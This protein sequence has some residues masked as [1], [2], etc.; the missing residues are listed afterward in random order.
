MK[1]PLTLVLPWLLLLVIAAAPLALRYLLVESPEIARVCDTGHSLAC[2]VRHAT[3]LGFIT[4]NLGGLRIGVFGWV[5]LAAMVLALWRPGVAT[6]WL[7]AATALFAV[8]LYCFEPGALA[9]L[10]GCLCLVRAQSGRASPGDQGRH[11]QREV[12]A[13]P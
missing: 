7:A 11:A 6:A 3:V 9:L 2:T 13:Q 8:V 1:R 5:A 4:G 10:V 12:G